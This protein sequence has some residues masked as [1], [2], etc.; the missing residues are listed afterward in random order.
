[1]QRPAT[2]KRLPLG[3]A[4]TGLIIAGAGAAFADNGQ[5]AHPPMSVA[6]VAGGLS[7]D[8]PFDDVLDDI[9]DIVQLPYIPRY[10]VDFD[11]DWYGDD[12]RGD[13]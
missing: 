4:L 10:F 3:A 7:S 12:D 11:D 8:W 6:P 1:M 13:D 5:S 2:W 9:D